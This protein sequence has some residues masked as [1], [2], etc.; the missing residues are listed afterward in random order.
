MKIKTM[1]HKDDVFF[2]NAFI[3]AVSILSVALIGMIV[4]EELG[5]QGLVLFGLFMAGGIGS[6]LIHGAAKEDEEEIERAQ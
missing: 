6:I 4:H 3:G 1:T 2:H 5:N